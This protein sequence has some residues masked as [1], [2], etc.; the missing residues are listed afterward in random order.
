MRWKAHVALLSVAFIYGANYTIAKNV[1]DLGYLKPNAFILLR[2]VSGFILFTLV[3]YVFIKEKIAKSDLPLLGI[4]GL[5]GIAFNQLFFFKGLSTTSPIHA[6]L[7]MVMTPIIVLIIS[8][9]Y[10]KEG[11][12]KRKVIGIALGMLGAILLIVRGSVDFDSMSS[13]RGDLYILINAISYGLYLVLV[14]GL[15]TSYHP[16]TV[17]KWIFSFG[18]IVVI[19][20]GISDLYESNWNTFPSEIWF[21]IAYVLLFT[22]FL[23]Y[24]LN[25][26]ALT[27]VNA[28]TASSYVY[29]QPLIASSIAI[30]WYN[31]HLSMLN[32]LSGFLIFY[33]VYLISMKKASSQKP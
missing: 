10:L 25:A 33:G 29:M 1:L 6:S 30:L 24:L 3:H 23:A 18:L 2:V 28:T 31:D 26:Y 7:I 9:L 19:P 14:K 13:I 5:F 27:L 17:M 12:N 11:I 16:F 8:S 15:M 21:A 32:V 4:C 22:T 20:F